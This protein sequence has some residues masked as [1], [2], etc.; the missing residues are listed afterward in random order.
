MRRRPDQ[1]R[2]HPD[3]RQ[4]LEPVRH[5]RKLHI[6]V[7]HEP[8]HRPQRQREVQRPR[9]RPASQPLPPQPQQ[10]RQPR[11]RRHVPP[12]RRR[13][14]LDLPPRIDHR[15]LHRPQ[16][17]ARV[18]PQRPP[19]DQRP[20]GQ[21]VA[22]LQ[23][24]P[25]PVERQVRRRDR[26]PDHRQRRQPQQIQPPHPAP[27][28]PVP[29]QQRQRQRHHHRLAQQPGR[30]QHHRQQVAARPRRL[31]EA[32]PHQHRAQVE[33]RR[34]HVLALDDPGH[35]LHVQRVHREHGGDQHR[36]GHPQ[37]QQQAPQQQA[38]EQVQEDVDGVVA[39]GPQAPQ[40]VLQPEAGVDQRPVVALVLDVGGGEPDAAQPAG[41]VDHRLLGE[42]HVVPHEAA[43][44][45]REVAHHHQQRQRQRRRRVVR[46]ERSQPRRRAAPYSA[47][48]PCL[49]RRAPHRLDWQFHAVSPGWSCSSAATRQAM[50]AANVSGAV[51]RE[52]ATPGS[53]AS[54]R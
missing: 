25:P 54:N 20:L 44:Q 29:Q 39:G 48:R 41:G 47:A 42:D 7:V 15:Q 8:Q 14:R 35:R 52:S 37:A 36:A 9:Q 53:S 26:R 50:P 1:H 18:E 51:I 10:Q 21:R 23:H 38:V 27:L 32:H 46:R 40:L 13:P 17:L 2:Q 5:E 19:R 31:H 49:P 45:R 33:Q 12:P 6:A 24:L 34:Q 11:R 16:Q 43:L 28:P 30:E 22:Q 3:P 4:V